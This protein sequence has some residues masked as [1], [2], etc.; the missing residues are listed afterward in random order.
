MAQ[1]SP[2]QRNA[3]YLSEAVRAGIHKPLLAALYEVHSQPR[4]MDGETGLGISPANAVS[5]HQVNTF[6][7]QVHYAASTIR[8]ITNS[9]TAKGWSSGDLWDIG[10]GC[11]SDRFLQ[12]VS[13][14]YLP[15]ISD[16]TAAR[17]EACDLE[18]LLVAYTAE[19]KAD[20]NQ[21]DINLDDS[22][23]PLNSNSVD[24]DQA[25]LI[26]V[27]RIAPNYSQLA[28]QQAALIEAV[29]LW[30]KLDTQTAAIQALTVPINEGVVD[31]EALDRALIQFMRQLPDAYGGYPHQR[32]ALL[33]LVQLWRQLDSREAVIRFLR[34]PDPPLTDVG[35]AIID[36][37]L[38][39]LIQRLP[40]IY[41]SQ[42]SQRFALT[43]AFRLWY[44]LDS[45][46]SALESL[47]IDPQSLTA[48]ADNPQALV[49]T[50][51]QVDRALLAFLRR[52]PSLYK[53]TENQRE[54]LLQLVQMWRKLD[55]RMGA[56]QSLLAD[57]RQMARANRNS[58]DAP[59]PPQPCLP[60][61][62]PEHWTAYNLQLDSA[63]ASNSNFTWADATQGG[64]HMP[65]NQ[66]T[67]EAIIRIAQL[68]QEACDRIGRPFQI[69]RWYDRSDANPSTAGTRRNRH[70]IGDAIDF[71]CNGLSGNQIYWA[72]DPWWPGGLGRYTRFPKLIHINA[73]DYQVRWRR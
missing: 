38:I 18:K 47:G 30:R 9:L 14:G 55:N 56:V 24:V 63:I 7:E 12:T 23:D 45:R 5:V 31:E 60:P 33:R 13:A 65:P 49:D 54:S 37:A 66:A 64:V 46:T 43:E 51:T 1:L 20:I 21:A 27:E 34:Q 11:Y 22:A 28:F 71:Y 57:L 15:P 26:F 69:T 41:Q 17:L 70:C 68:A 59:Q 2:G 4:L 67:V 32:E 53:E 61:P 3:V 8:S 10:Q 62:R 58:P 52:L 44:G 40:E 6:A 50:A 19:I 39:A 73:A 42:G 29:R 25:L 36:P 35:L 48:N 16:Q 72:L